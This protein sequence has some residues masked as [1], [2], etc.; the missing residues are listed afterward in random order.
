MR[1]GVNPRDIYRCLVEGFDYLFRAKV[2]PRKTECPV[3]CMAGEGDAKVAQDQAR[4]CHELLLHLGEQLAILNE[5]EGG[6]AHCQV[7]NL[8]LV[9]PGNP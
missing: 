1:I 6:K 2:D 7:D 3:L 5:K 4:A 8:D 9:W